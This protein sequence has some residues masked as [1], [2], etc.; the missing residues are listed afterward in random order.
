MTIGPEPMTRTLEMSFGLVLGGGA[1]AAR[2]LRV[3]S[4]IRST[5]RSKR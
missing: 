3:V 2:P 1:V 5:N 4:A